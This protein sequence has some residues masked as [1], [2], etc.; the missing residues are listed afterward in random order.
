MYCRACITTTGHTSWAIFPLRCISGPQRGHGDW[1]TCLHFP[2]EEKQVRKESLGHVSL[3][4]PWWKDAEG[5]NKVGQKSGVPFPSSFPSFL[6]LVPPFTWLLTRGPF[7]FWQQQSRARNINLC[8]SLFSG[9]PWLC[10]C[11]S[12]IGLCLSETVLQWQ[13]FCT[14]LT[15][16]IHPLIFLSWMLLY[17]YSLLVCTLFLHL[18]THKP[19]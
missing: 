8:Q 14:T 7:H 1:R 9:G 5:G 18:F 3:S 4:R 15:N 17:C 12:V 6:S 16:V 13:F 19:P 10:K 11:R 2:K